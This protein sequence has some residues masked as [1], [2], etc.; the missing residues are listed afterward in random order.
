[1]LLQQDEISIRLMQDDIDDYQLM[2]KSLTDDKV[3][4]DYEGRDN[5]FA[6]DRIL[7]S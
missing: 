1:M 4:K 3:L 5:P 6:L 2:A 7:E